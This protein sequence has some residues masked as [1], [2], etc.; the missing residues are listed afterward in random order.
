MRIL[1][2]ADLHYALPQYDWVMEI[3]GEFDVVIIA[4]DHLDT[5]SLVDFRAQTVVVQKYL[6][7]LK[8]RTQLI[9]CSGNHDLDARNEAGEKVTRWIL[10]YQKEG[11]PTDGDSFVAG[12]TLFTI[13]PWWDGPMVRD[14]IGRQFAADQPKRLKRWVWV[15]HAP[16]DQSPVS[17]G[18][19]RYFGD[20]DLVKWI[21]EHRPDIVFSGH[22]HQS[23]FV[24]DGSWVDRVGETWVFNAGHQFGAPPAH[25][26]VDTERDVALWFSAAGNQVVNLS[27]PLKR[28]VE[29]LHAL[30]DWLTFGDRAGGPSPGLPPRPDGA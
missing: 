11:V 6:S 1:V 30:P 29:V 16:P 21:G 12:D 15:H 28:P 13:C 18:G 23:P 9:V 26:I 7:R 14:S 20:V 24:K 25:I 22:V 10:R 27:E 19:G 2:V 4:G 3:A 17:W 8:E 5:T